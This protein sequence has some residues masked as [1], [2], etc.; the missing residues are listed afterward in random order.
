[1]NL[2]QLISLIRQRRLAFVY[3]LIA[4]VAF[5]GISFGACSTGPT[6]VISAIFFPDRNISFAAHVKPFLNESCAQSG[7]HE[8]FTRAGNLSLVT[9]TDLLRNPGTVSP[10]DSSS[11]VLCQILSERLPHTQPIIQFSTLNQR[12]GV[13]IWI[14]EGAFNN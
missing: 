10:G 8:E 2:A 9:Y 12:R 5:I 1:M 14:Q 13:C 4:L 11:S 6:G 3:S 7:C